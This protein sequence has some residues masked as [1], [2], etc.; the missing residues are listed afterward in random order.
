MSSILGHVS[1]T[2]DLAVTL[3]RICKELESQPEPEEEDNSVFLFLKR[4]W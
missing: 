3:Q 2:G 1:V 4:K